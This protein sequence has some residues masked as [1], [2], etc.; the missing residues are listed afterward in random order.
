MTSRLAKYDERQALKTDSSGAF[1]PDNLAQA[2]QL[3]EMLAE[4]NFVPQAFK[5]KPGDVLVAMQ[6]GAEVGLSHMQAL[7]NIAP[8]NGRPSIWGDAVLGL[9]LN[10]PRCLDVIE[11]FDEETQ[12]ATCTVKIRNRTDVVRTFSLED[13]KRAGLAG[14]KGPWQEF[15]RRMLQM[16]ARG[17]AI[18][19][20]FPDV[21]RG[22]SL[23]EEAQ[24]LPAPVEAQAEEAPPPP[25]KSATARLKARKQ[26]AEEPAQEAEPEPEEPPAEEVSD[27]ADPATTAMEAMAYIRAAQTMDELEAADWTPVKSL[28]DDLKKQ[29]RDA[30]AAKKAELG[31][32]G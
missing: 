5:G 23:R 14:K 6:M 22:L 2:M 13:A 29:V 19:D 20:A 18:R 28:S 10:D 9:A 8:I 32:E 21:L 24:D 4:S 1:K 31:G 25:S 3:A 12:T 26:Q 7:Q 17:F 11:T 15:R 27:E 30:Y 16:R